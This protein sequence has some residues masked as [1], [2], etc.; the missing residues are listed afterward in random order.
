LA[1][2]AVATPFAP[3]GDGDA[4]EEG[5]RP[6]AVGP[7]NGEGRTDRLLAATGEQDLPRVAV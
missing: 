4:G 6:T 7:G 2:R 1:L 5:V 3:V